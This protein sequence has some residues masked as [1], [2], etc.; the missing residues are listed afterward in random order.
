MVRQ[1]RSGFTLV[2]LLIV[3]VILAILA[4]AIIPTFT[5]STTDARASTA[6]TN[7]NVLRGQIQMY[8]MQ[9]NGLTPSET[10]LELTKQTNAS[11]GE[12][13]DF[14][15]YLLKIPTNPYTNSNRVRTTATNPPTAAS[16]ESDAGWLYHAASGNIWLDHADHLDD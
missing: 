13:T 12:G 4:A 9:H 8:R 14:G 7:L 5:D 1:P 15:P 6:L 16:G 11:G 3:V 2:E 10:L